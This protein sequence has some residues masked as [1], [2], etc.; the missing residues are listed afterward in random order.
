MKKLV[1]LLLFIVLAGGCYWNPT[2][3]PPHYADFGFK[4]C[5]LLLPPHGN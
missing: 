4:G 1:I 2:G 3:I 5:S